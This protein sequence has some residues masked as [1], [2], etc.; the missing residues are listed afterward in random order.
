MRTSTL[1]RRGFLASGARLAAFAGLP[2]WLQRAAQ[3]SPLWQSNQSTLAEL[4]AQW[5]SEIGGSPFD[6]AISAADLQTGQTGGVNGDQIRYPG[7]T[8]NLFILMSVIRDVQE[9]RYPEWEVGDAISYTI[10][11]SSAARARQLLLKTG[12]GDVARGIDKVNELIHSLG[13]TNTLF[14]HPPGYWEVD[15]QHDRENTT[16]ANEMRA[17]LMALWHDRVLE[18]RWTDYLLDKM[19][20]VKP[21]LNYLIAG[22]VPVSAGRRVSHKNGFLWHPAARWVDN[23]VGVVW[24]ATGPAAR[25]G[26]AITMFFQ[27]VPVEYGNIW[28]GQRLSWLTWR[29]LGGAG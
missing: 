27:N 23:D 2:S 3:P 17:A 9:G 24:Q 21:G 1:S 5:R 16:T 8:L 4:Q 15:S 29:A 18:H 6:T 19:T 11:H 20:Q 25:R 14:D 28:L 12:G 10:R 13:L 22:G 26:Y 7:C